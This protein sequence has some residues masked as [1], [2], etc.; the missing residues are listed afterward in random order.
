MDNI[1]TVVFDL[2]NTLVEIKKS[3]H[4]FVKLFKTSQDGFGMNLSSYLQLIMKK[5]IEQLKNI[6]PNE[7]SRL[8]DERLN[9]LMKEL[10]S[11]VVYT[12]VIDVLQSLKDDFRIFM[13]SNLASPYR[14]PVFSNNLDQYFEEM[15]FSCDVGFLKPNK[16][17]FKEIE[18]ITGNKPNEILMIGDSFKSDIIGAKNMG[19]NYLKIS[20]NNIVLKDYEIKSLTEIRKNIKPFL[21]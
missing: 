20:R 6:L 14:K 13:I 4:F 8:Y 1:K 17:I 10:D 18:K 3:N 19:W 2:Y 15:I 21:M 9:D 12:E 11:I 5:D 16:E 7:F